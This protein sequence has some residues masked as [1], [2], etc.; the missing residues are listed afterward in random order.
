MGGMS[1]REVVTVSDARQGLS[2]ILADLSAAGPEAEP[3]MIGA[4]RKPQG[5]L[6]SVEAFEE[7]V[8]RHARREEMESATASV[9]AEGLRTS[10]AANRDA[11]AYVR[12]EISAEEMVARTI[13]RYKGLS[14]RQAG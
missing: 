11:E 2:K 10:A 1:I 12:G 7:L 5:V 14:H 8:G 6:L 9:E 3:V 13:A 4:H